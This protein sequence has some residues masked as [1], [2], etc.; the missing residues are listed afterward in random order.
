M[1]AYTVANILRL[2]MDD[3]EQL[4]GLRMG[5]N[6]SRLWVLEHSLDKASPLRPHR[7][8]PRNL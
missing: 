8:P 6:R 3:L 4:Y 1:Q 5:K 7:L 2:A